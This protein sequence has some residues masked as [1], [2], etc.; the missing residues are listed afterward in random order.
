MPTPDIL[1]DVLAATSTA[2]MLPENVPLKRIKANPYQSRSQYTNIEELALDIERNGLLQPAVGRRNGLTVELAIGHRRWKAIEWL[3]ENRPDTIKWR[4]MP[5]VTKPL[6]DDTM[7]RIVWSENH[8]RDNIS[9]VDEARHMQRMIASAPLC[10][11]S[12]LTNSTA[13]ASCSGPSSRPRTRTPVASSGAD[14]TNSFHRRQPDN[15]P[16]PNAPA[17]YSRL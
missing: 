3:N 16:Y 1:G 12:I 15:D 14:T 11:L 4:T 13:P 17:Y 10:S 7:A 6:G 9:P 5:V 2:G 8:Q